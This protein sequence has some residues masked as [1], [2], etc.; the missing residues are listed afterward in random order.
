MDL[1]PSNPF[2]GIKLGILFLWSLELG[3]AGVTNQSMWVSLQDEVELWIEP[4]E[5]LAQNK[6]ADE[7]TVLFL[8][9]QDLQASIKPAKIPQTKPKQKR[10]QTLSSSSM[11]PH[12]SHCELWRL[13]VK[14][15]FL[16][17]FCLWEL[18]VVSAS[19]GM[20][21]DMRH[22]MSAQACLVQVLVYGHNALHRDLA[23]PG[24]SARTMPTFTS[25]RSLNTWKIWSNMCWELFLS[26]F[27]YGR[28][29]RK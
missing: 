17:I 11:K 9:M 19:A 27:F 15:S 4:G 6:A 26:S 5:L 16:S 18:Q 21:A 3:Y 2:F 20:T 23:S 1:I 8:I 10:P 29:K 28:I 14:S 22:K 13:L 7:L 24:F 25:L 12:S